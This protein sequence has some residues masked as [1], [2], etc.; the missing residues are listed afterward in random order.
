MRHVHDGHVVHLQ[1]RVVDTQTPVRGR[2]TAR[3]EL[4]D[5]NGGVVAEVRIV[6]AAGDAET[7]ARASSLQNYLLILPVIVAVHLEARKSPFVILAV[8]SLYTYV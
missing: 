1:Y 8:P 5:V 7:E 2:G 6:R 4:R 3:Y